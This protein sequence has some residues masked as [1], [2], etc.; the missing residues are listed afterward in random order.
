MPTYTVTN[1]NFNLKSKE[2]IDLANS[3]TNIHSLVTGANTYFAQ[4]IFN[5]T[6][7][8]DHFMG[9]K[10]LKEP[11]IFL[12]GQIRSGRTKKIKDKLIKDLRNII[13]KKT[14]LDKTQI[15]VYIMDLSPSQMIEYGEV[16]PKSGKENIWFSNLSK[17]LKNKLSTLENK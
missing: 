15:W 11:Q 17:K 5:K 16:L 3:I 14:K 6:K 13:I 1:S 12:V 10:L 4:V 7:K 9:G 2:K 8:R